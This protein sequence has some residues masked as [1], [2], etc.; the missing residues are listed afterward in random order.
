[1]SFSPL[2]KQK[3]ETAY[4]KLS[5]DNP[6]HQITTDASLLGW[7]VECQGISSGGTWTTLEAP[8]HINYLE[9]LAISFGLQTFAKD[10]ANTHIPVRCDNTTAVNIINHVGS[11]HSEQRKK[12][13][14][15]IWEWCI[16][17]K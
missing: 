10:K 13:A 11:S 12:L 16:N 8:N 14:K 15:T 5:Q 7:E 6:V 3:L 4:K 1:M 17:T 2:A 9:M